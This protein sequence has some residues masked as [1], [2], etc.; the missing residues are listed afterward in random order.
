MDFH[1]LERIVPDEL[2]DGA[3]TGQET[4]RLH[5]ER[6]RFAAAHSVGRCLDLA[7]GVGYGSDLLLSAGT[8][9]EVVGVDIAADAVAYARTRYG[10]PGLTFLQ[11]DGMGFSDPDG[12]DTIV[13]LETLE[14][15]EDPAGQLGHFRGLLRSGGVLVASVPVTPSM[16]A[17]PHHLHDFTPRTFRRLVQSLGLREESHL[18]QVQPFN[19]LRILSGTEVRASRVRRGLASHYARHPLQL[20]R[21]LRALARHGFTNRYL[22]LV[23]RAP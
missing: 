4:L 9:S 7:C 6:Y 23:V 1:S 5:L 12:F 19:P 3:T 18:L 16:D 2:E 15:L 17:N 21:R 14:H 11:G 8:V 22:T 20:L 13:T 10:R